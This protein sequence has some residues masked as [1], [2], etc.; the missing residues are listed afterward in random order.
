MQRRQQS[1]SAPLPLMSPPIDA[2]RMPIS[3]KSRIVDRAEIHSFPTHAIEEAIAFVQST[4]YTEPRS[5]P[6]AAVSAGACHPSRYA[7]P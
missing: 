5:A 7:R 6:C 4:L 3:I 1:I 2:L